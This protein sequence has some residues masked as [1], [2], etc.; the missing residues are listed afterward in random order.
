M[1]ESLSGSVLATACSVTVKYTVIEVKKAPAQ[2]TMEPFFFLAY[3]RLQIKSLNTKYYYKTDAFSSF[4]L[5]RVDA[6]QT[7]RW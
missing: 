7:E 1:E 3:N 6:L 2:I 5:H 4:G